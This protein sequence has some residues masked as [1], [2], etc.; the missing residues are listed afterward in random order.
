G[1]RVYY[2]IDGKRDE[3][4]FAYT[5]YKH[6]FFAQAFATTGGFQ[7][8]WLDYDAPALFDSPWRLRSQLIY[9]RNTSRN[10][11][12]VGER[13]L[14]LAFPGAPGKFSTYDAYAKALERVQPDG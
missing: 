14:D 11:F 4:L 10:Y 9:E 1:A 2:F 5:P 7:F 8:H 6:R 13:A 3:P 12:G